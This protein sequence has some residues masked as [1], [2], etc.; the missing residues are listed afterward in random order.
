MYTTNIIEKLTSSSDCN[1]IFHPALAASILSTSIFIAASYLPAV[2]CR[3][4][5][6]ISSYPAGICSLTS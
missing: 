5:L 2:N 4:R 3:W 1:E 6:G